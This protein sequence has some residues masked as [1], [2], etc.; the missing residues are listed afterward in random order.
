ML[1]LFLRITLFILIDFGMII[2]ISPLFLLLF[3]FVN[4]IKK[5]NNNKNTIVVLIHGSGVKGWQ[6][7]I[8]EK[9]L[10]YYNIPYKSVNYDSSQKIYKSCQDV[11]EQIISI[12]NCSIDKKNVV[13][14]GHS[15]GGL[16]ARVISS[17]MKIKLLFLINTPQNGAIVINWLD[18]GASLSP[19][20]YDLRYGSE[21]ITHLPAPNACQVHEIVGINDFIRPEHATTHGKNVYMSYFGHYFS[22]VNPYLWFGYIIPL[23]RT[24]GT[25]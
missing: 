11:M 22:A 19:A 21:F 20:A 1:L 23:I 7:I 2:L 17:K 5:N 14:I 12:D 13:L 6:W 24:I 18:S 25:D 9:Y 10:Y 15:L 8:V 4:I 3:S 16:I